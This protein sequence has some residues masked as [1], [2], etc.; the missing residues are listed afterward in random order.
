[1]PG[2]IGRATLQAK[3]V[4]EFYKE[5]R[6]R[7][8]VLSGKAGT[9]KSALAL[10]TLNWIQDRGLISGGVVYVNCRFTSSLSQLKKDFCDKVENDKSKWMQISRF[11]SDTFSKIIEAIKRTEET[12][13]FLF[14]NVRADYTTFIEEIHNEC[15]QVKVIMTCR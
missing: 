3:L 5:K 13:I 2:F 15:P 7:W 10:H 11:E 4:D 14:D 9:G 12:F 6:N 8:L 1:M